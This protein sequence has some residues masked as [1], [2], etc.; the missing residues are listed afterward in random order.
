MMHANSRDEQAV[1]RL[2]EGRGEPGALAR[3]LDP[4]ALLACRDSVTRERLS[5]AQRRILREVHDVQRR[6]AVLERKF[7]GRLQGGLDEVVREWD[8]SRG[9]RDEVHR[10][11]G[12][13]LQRGGDVGHVSERGAHEEELGPP[14][15]KQRNLPRP[16]PVRIAVVVELVHRHP[17]DAGVLALAQRLVCQDL[18]RTAHHRRARVY[19][20]VSSHH[21]HIVTAEHVDEVEKLLAYERLDGSGIVGGVVCAQRH[22][23]HAQ[24]DQRLARASGGAQHH[25]VARGNR[26]QRLLLVFPQLQPTSLHPFEEQLEGLLAI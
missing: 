26:E 21:A 25:M 1:K 15:G 2:A 9:V 11:P 24:G 3:V 23:A 5:A 8:G 18:G 6:I 7:H 16:S 22:E 20:D 17:C 12:A 13:L 14:E 19:R 10:D 4:V